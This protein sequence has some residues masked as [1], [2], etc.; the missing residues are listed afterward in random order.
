MNSETSIT[1]KEI[2]IELPNPT[3][4]IK[5]TPYLATAFAEGFCEGEGALIE[6]QIE[7]WACLIKTGMCWSLQGTFGRGAKEL[8]DGGRI[9]KD[10]T[11]V[12]ELFDLD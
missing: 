7:A 9:K 4:D 1:E 2:F 12:W 6:H 10:G 11:I 8:I 3:S 5:W